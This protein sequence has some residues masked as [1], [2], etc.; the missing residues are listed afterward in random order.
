M[1]KKISSTKNKA[2]KKLSNLYSHL[3]KIY[4]ILFMNK[5]VHTQGKE[6]EYLGRK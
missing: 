4:E 3:M 1:R 6:W 2:L 5:C